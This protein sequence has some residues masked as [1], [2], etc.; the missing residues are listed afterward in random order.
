M[1]SAYKEEA[2]HRK[3][4]LCWYVCTFQPCRKLLQIA[5][6]TGRK[7]EMISKEADFLGGKYTPFQESI[8]SGMKRVYMYLSFVN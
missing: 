5:M 8:S 3:D 7:A 6:I 2:L 1:C 4:R